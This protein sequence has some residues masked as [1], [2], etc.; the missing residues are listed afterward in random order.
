[1]PERSIEEV[2]NELAAIRADVENL[3]VATP[4][5]RASSEWSA[6][7]QWKSSSSRLLG[8]FG[9]SSRLRLPENT[10]LHPQMETVIRD[11]SSDRFLEI[12][13]SLKKELAG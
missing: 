11:V 5:M 8:D 1:M 4:I 9:V 13:K 12:A 6:H 3:R 7:G 10:E 2:N